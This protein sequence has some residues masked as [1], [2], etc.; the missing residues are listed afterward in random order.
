[1][2]ETVRRRIS[3][4]AI[5]AGL[6]VLWP[7]IAYI[8]EQGFTAGI[9]LAAIP[10]LF[11]A[12][13]KSLPLYAACFI[14]FMLWVVISSAWS[15]AGGGLFEGSFAEQ[16]FALN[17]A[18]VRIG[19]TGLCIGAVVFAASQVDAYA[20]RALAVF[21]AIPV[22]Q[23]IGVII[24]A[25]FM[26][27]ILQAL[28][29]S[30]DPVTEMPQNMMRNVNA[31]TLILPLLLAWMWRKGGMPYRA[32]AIAWPLVI[33]WAAAVIGS[34]A[35]IIAIIFIGISSLIERLMER[36]GFLV[37]LTLLGSYI[38]LAPFIFDGLIQMLR[39]TGLPI[40]ASFWSRVHAWDSVT[41]RITEAPITGHGLEA[42]K[43]WQGVY[44]DQPAR[45]S[46]I[47]ADTGLPNAGWEAYA[48]VPGHP[49]NMALQIWAETGFI[50]ALLV[51]LTSLFVGVR[52]YQLGPIPHVAKYAGAGLFGA[53]LAFFAFSYSMWNEAFWGSVA[54]AATFVILHGR[55]AAD[56]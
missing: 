9:A 25:L 56:L 50:G 39:G 48:I 5:L 19:L 53:T 16:T 51:A 33:A 30:S 11:F 15:S 46:E 3:Y 54:L 42:S 26:G 2:I 18:S 34:Q 22:I 32:A 49:H 55:Y 36:T 24:T 43:T 41:D 7:I 31:L 23:A 38:L 1:M 52:L 8:G 10:V 13:P 12:Q 40:P 45:L 35:A 17:A 28:A 14:A 6:F 4:P 47:I 37:L 44:A 29:F 21:K 20:P 27:A